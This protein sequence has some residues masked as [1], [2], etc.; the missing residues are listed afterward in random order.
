[1]A[2]LGTVLATAVSGCSAT[3]EVDPD[4][5]QEWLTTQESVEV[6]GA[7]AAMSGVASALSD[8]VEAEGITA[9]FEEPHPVVSVLFACFGPETMSAAVTLSG[10]D[11]DD[12]PTSLVIRTDDLSCDGE[13]QKIDMAMDAAIAV[14]TNGL[15]VGATGGW[16]AVVV[17][18]D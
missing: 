18:E 2:V 13:S 15:S 5:V 9:T 7:L 8:T 16:S 4:A 3:P 14:T 6:P 17:G 1:M 10:F 12:S 11:A